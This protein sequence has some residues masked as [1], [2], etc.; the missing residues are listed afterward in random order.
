MRAAAG[1]CHA[2]GNPWGEAVEKRAAKELD[3]PTFS[4][5]ADYF[6]SVCCLSAYEARSQKIARAVAQLL[7][8]AGVSY[9]IIGADECCCGESIRKTGDEEEFKRL[10]KNNISLWEKK[11]LKRIIATS[12]HC[13]YTFR[14]EYRDL[15][16]EV[17]VVHYTEILAELIRE[18]KI[19]PTK[20][21]EI[22]VTYHDPCYLGR[23]SDIYDAPR[24]IIRAIPGVEFVEMERS[25]EDSLCCG[26]G[27]A[28]VWME[29]PPEQRFSDLRV[30]EAASTGAKILVTACPYCI[31]ML[32]DSLK[33]T[34]IEDSLE[35]VDLSELVA[36]A[37]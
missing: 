37:M 15:G 21:R 1:S 32:E 8:T 4:P 13:Y 2:N 36:R 3:V 35:V 20:T 22:K 30:K 19:R 25:R 27:G 16:A 12:P 29:T 33:S 9:G 18:E 10:A 17:D 23:H 7:S 24:E 34:N 26:G 6:L 14:E 31:T 5:D 11:K 28:R